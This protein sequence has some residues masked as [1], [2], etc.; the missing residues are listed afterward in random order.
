MAITTEKELGE[1]L[2]DNRDY[3]EIEGDL[4]TKLLR[5]ARQGKSRG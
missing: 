1:A 5:Y 4:V 3:I 2:K